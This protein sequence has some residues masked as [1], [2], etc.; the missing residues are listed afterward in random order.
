MRLRRIS[1][2]SAFKRFSPVLILSLL[3]AAGAHRAR[4]SAQTNVEVTFASFSY[5]PELVYITAG[6]SVTWQGNFFAHPLTSDD[7]LWA[8]QSSGDSFSYTF[9]NA[10]VFL[11]YCTIHGGPGG[12]GM[13][14]QVIVT[15][16][17][18]AYMPLVVK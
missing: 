11:Y 3:Y 13:S 10:G 6:D 2:G 8:T 18:T 4:A 1:A 5:A 17:F 15:G 9:Q 7:G 16:P 14:G 12:A